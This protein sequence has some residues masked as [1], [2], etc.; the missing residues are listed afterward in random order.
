M[1]GLAGIWPRNSCMGKMTITQQTLRSLEIG[2]MDIDG[3]GITEIPI[4]EP[5]PGYDASLGDEAM[6][7]INYS[8]VDSTGIV[9]YTSVVMNLDAGYMLEFPDSWRDKVT[10]TKQ[11]KSNEWHFWIYDGSLSQMRGELLRI[12]V[13]STKDYMINSIP[14]PIGSLRREAILSISPIFLPIW[15][16]NT[17]SPM[18]S[19]KPCFRCCSGRLTGKDGLG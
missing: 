12:K 15:T 13:Y 5:L 1:T 7:L 8:A 4:L 2:S 17:P 11:D 3:D 19:W 14:I 9:R 10:I 16:R 18:S 6:Y